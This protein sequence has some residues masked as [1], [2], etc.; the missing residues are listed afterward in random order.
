[1]QTHSVTKVKSSMPVTSTKHPSHN[2]CNGH[3]YQHKGLY[4]T[5]MQ[6]TKPGHKSG[7]CWPVLI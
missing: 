7:N 1:M 3:V 6:G 4:A 2:V 5:G